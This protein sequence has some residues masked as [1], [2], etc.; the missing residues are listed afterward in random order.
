MIMHDSMC[1]NYYHNI[2]MFSESQVKA[3]FSFHQ[4]VSIRQQIHCVEIL[5]LI[6]KVIKL[7]YTQ[8]SQFRKACIF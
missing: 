6:V 8:Y 1:H 4:T 3:A 7:K 2:Y 5:K